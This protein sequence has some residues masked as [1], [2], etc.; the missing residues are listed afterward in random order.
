MKKL[1]WLYDLQN[2]A[3]VLI[4]LIMISIGSVMFLNAGA[5]LYIFGFTSS[6]Y[7]APEERCE[8]NN[9][10]A[11]DSRNI[12]K[13][14]EEITLCIEKEEKKEQNRYT[15]SKQEDI[16]NGIILIII[17]FPLWFFHR[18]RKAKEEEK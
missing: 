14:P 2:F 12:K 11:P 9:S 16:I 17:G 3:G 18:Q 4:G 5:K 8:N 7:F 10:Y 13:T 15:R 6:S 1:T